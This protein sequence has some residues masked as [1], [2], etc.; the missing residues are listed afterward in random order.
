MLASSPDAATVTW[1]GI[2]IASNPANWSG[3]AIPQ[4]GDDV[5]FNNTSTQNCTWDIN[6]SLKSFSINSGY[7]G[8]V[9]VSSNL[10]VTGNVKIV[11]GALNA[12]SAT[13]TVGGDWYYFSG[14]STPLGDI[15][16]DG[17]IDISDVMLVLRIALKLDPIQPCSD[18]N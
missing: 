4:N 14:A 11:Y 10:T 3:G 9:S 5:V 13:I 12:G 2:G 8:T 18:L 6:P 15:N 1:T 7:T 16:K 17:I